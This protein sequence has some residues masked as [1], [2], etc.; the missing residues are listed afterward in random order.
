MRLSA[1]HEY[2]T[3]QERYQQQVAA[4]QT[5][6]PV[7]IFTV[8]ENSRQ[9]PVFGDGSHVQQCAAI[10]AYNFRKGSSPLSRMENLSHN[11]NLILIVESKNTYLKF[12]R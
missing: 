6:Q 7:M 11:L 10:P 12:F 9:G 4:R 8:D 5:G 2:M 3:R 1:Y